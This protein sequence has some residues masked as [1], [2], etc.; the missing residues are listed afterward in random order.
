MKATVVYRVVQ[1]DTLQPGD[2]IIAM[3]HFC[4]CE[5]YKGYLRKLQKYEKNMLEVLQITVCSS[6][7]F[8]GRKILINNCI[9]PPTGNHFQHSHSTAVSELC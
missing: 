4:S 7:L 1:A 8:A 9:S 3:K 5:T 2:A 6:E